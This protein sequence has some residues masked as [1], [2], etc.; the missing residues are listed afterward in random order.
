[1]EI[2]QCMLT[3]NDCYRTGATINPKQIVVHSTGANNKTLKRY[4]Q[5][6]D[7]ILGENRYKN[8]WNRSGVNKCVNAFIGV[9]KDNNIRIYQ[10]L[11]WTMRPWGCGSGR[12]GSYNNSAIQFEI[13]EDDLSDQSYFLSAMDA[14]AELCAFLCNKYGIQVNEVVSHHEA[15]LRGY[16]SNHGDI[17]HWLRRYS[18]TMDWFRG[19]VTQKLSGEAVV[20]AP[21][22][23]PA[24]ENTPFRV[25]VT[26]D[27]LNI[28][29]GAG[30][31][32]KINGSIKDK[33]VYTIVETNGDWG[34]LKS[35]AGWI[36]LL[37]TKRI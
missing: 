4:V 2:R 37:Y 11:P 15:C 9:D 22:E 33:G 17:D 35:G 26:A 6:D 16:A 29:A 19:L 20:E 10:T 25:K 27:V 36:S 13:C 3:K 14:A 31:N 5:P 18:K 7:G 24:A 1:M 21:V 23:K 12:K 34:R 32:Y 30:T 8:D 28:R